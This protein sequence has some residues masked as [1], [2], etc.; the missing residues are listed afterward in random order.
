[1]KTLLA[2]FSNTLAI[3]TGIDPVLPFS[4][5][6][7]TIRECVLETYAH[8]IYPFDMLIEDLN[9]NRDM[10][11][12]SLFDVMV[13]YRDTKSN[14]DELPDEGGLMISEYDASSSTSKFDITFSFIRRKEFI[15]L[16][17]EYNTDLFD[18]ERIERMQSHVEG[19]MDA[20]ATYPLMSLW[21]L[22]YAKEAELPALP[23]INLSEEKA[24]NSI[25]EMFE[26]QVAEAPHATALICEERTYTFSE[27]NDFANK[28]GVKL[29]N[30]FKVKPN[31]LVGLL[32]ERNEWMIFGILGILKAGGAYVPLDVSN[33]EDRIYFVLDD[34]GVDILI[35]AKTEWNERFTCL[36]PRQVM[37]DAETE[38]ADLPLVTEPGHLIYV[39]YTSGSTGLPKGAM[40]ENRSVLNLFDGYRNRM[41]VTEADK[42]LAITT[43]AFDI[44]V[45]ELLL[46]LVY[47]AQVILASGAE[48]NIPEALFG[49]MTRYKPTLMQ[50]TPSFWNFLIEN[51]MPAQLQLRVV[52]AGEALPLTLS[53]KILDKVGQLWNMYGPTETTIYATY[54][55]MLKT[56]SFITIGVPVDNTEVYI[57]DEYLQKVPFGIPGEMIIAGVGVAR[58]Y[59]NRE[60]L[61]K[62][63][64]IP[65]PF[66]IGL[67]YRTGDRVRWRSDGTIEFMGRMDN[68]IK[69]RGYRIELGEIEHTLR[70]QD[71]IHD[72]VVDVRQK[73][74]EKYLVAYY[75]TLGDTD[76]E[77]IRQALRKTLPDYM[78]PTY[79]IRLEAFPMTS[80]GKTDRNKLPEPTEI[81]ETNYQAP[82]TVIE[83]EIALI[84][85]E[86]LDREQVGLNDN[87]F[88]IGGYSVKAIQIIMRINKKLNLKLPVNLLLEHPTIRELAKM[89]AEKNIPA[90]TMIRFNGMAES[91]PNMYL[92]PTLVGTSM[93]Y[94]PLVGF[95]QD[96]FNCFGLQDRG[97]ETGEDA[98]I[99]LEEKA[100]RFADDILR[101]QEQGEVLLTGF[102]FGAITAW[103]TAKLLEKMG[104]KVTLVCLDSQVR[105][106]I[107]KNRKLEARNET[108]KKDIDLLD[109]EEQLKLLGFRG[110]Q[111]EQM[112]TIWHSNIRL[113]DNYKQSG[114]VNA[115]IIAFK[116]KSNTGRNFIDM[117]DWKG[118]TSGKFEHYYITGDHLDTISLPKNLEVIAR[119]LQELVMPVVSLV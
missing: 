98:D 21:Q 85:Q 65:N 113:C 27:L 101:N 108:D 9:L 105:R 62:E 77:L 47:G 70:K 68:Q 75:T 91:K 88:A 73:G 2:F 107:I 36:N 5:L 78:V 29:R 28:L 60:A 8:S 32:M 72:A 3:R 119:H 20:V 112:K 103:E 44:S 12:S 104:L 94:F 80:S 31:Q 6:I 59:L 92:F 96:S 22:P 7:G 50:G 69:L 67:A 89:I 99:S 106:K 57:V 30:D 93:I 118:Y 38:V 39:L 23:A 79:L 37:M 111:Y 46:P 18:R 71:N 95:L 74:E 114:K 115:P 90:G 56:D 35:T 117:K 81:I 66:G 84:W 48:A 64:F 86:I 26:R 100:S 63:K 40:I 42:M 54:G 33:P 51:D 14:K 1:M 49:L 43:Q 102:S 61:T 34:S 97:F 4:Q 109:A 25:I 87:F 10:S 16:G 58:G 76:K 19:L 82:A 53:H 24:A 55:R 17:V 83:K 110:E 41:Q 13:L 116:A 45:T 52:A 11:R 15:Q